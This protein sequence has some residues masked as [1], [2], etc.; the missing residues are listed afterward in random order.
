MKEVNFI[1]FYEILSEL[2]KAELKKMKLQAE[3]YSAVRLKSDILKK[4][5]RKK[6]KLA[7][8]VVD[9]FKIKKELEIN[10]ILAKVADNTAEV[11]PLLLKKYR[12]KSF[13]KKTE[14]SFYKD[15]KEMTGI[16]GYFPKNDFDKE[17]RVFIV[18]LKF[19]GEIRI[20]NFTLSGDVR[21]FIDNFNKVA[22]LDNVTLCYP[23]FEIVDDIELYVNNF[24]LLQEKALEAAIT[25]NRAV[26]SIYAEYGVAAKAVEFD[27]NQTWQY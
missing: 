8:L 20:I 22:T 18:H 12:G 26:E 17:R 16:S 23:E 3:L 14:Q 24:L 4:D 5:I 11:L 19:E 6:I 7:G 15:F 1:Q 9:K 10:S 21:Y 27:F 25:Y 13:G 2:E